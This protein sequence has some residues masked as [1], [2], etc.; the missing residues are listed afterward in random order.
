MEEIFIGTT[1]KI[2]I[3]RWEKTNNEPSKCSKCSGTGEMRFV[4]RFRSK[5]R[6][7]S[8]V[9]SRLKQLEKLKPTHIPRSTKRIHYSFPDTPR[10][11]NEVVSITDADKFYGDKPVYKNLNFSMIIGGVMS[12]NKIS[13]DNSDLH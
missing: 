10:S 2:K 7:A 5:A 6:K 9:Q 11:G 3:K 13:F 4:Q 8:Q 1:K 12:T